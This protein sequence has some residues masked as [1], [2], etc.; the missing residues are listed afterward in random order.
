MKIERMASIPLIL[1]DPYISIWSSTDKLYESDPVHWS[2]ARQK[3]TGHLILNGKPYRFMGKQDLCQNMEQTGVEVTATASTYYFE[4]EDVTLEVCFRSSFLLEDPVLVSRPC[5]YIDFRIGGAYEGKQPQ[6]AVQ[7][8][9]DIV[10]PGDE[11]VI[12]GAYERPDYHY[13]YMGKARQTPLCYSGDNRTIDWGYCYLASGQA[14]ADIRHDWQDRTLCA[15]FDLEQTPEANLIFAFDD[16]SSIQYFGDVKRGYWTT[17]YAHILDAIGAAIS[18]HDELK[19]RCAQFDAQL[20]AQARK[21]GG[22]DYALLCVAAYRHTIA[23][24][25]LIAD[26]DGNLIFLS[27]ETDSNG[28]IGTVDLSY[29]SSPMFLLYNTEYVKG[30]MRPIFHFAN[31]D[32]WEND[33]APHDV[34]RYPYAVGQVYALNW[35]KPGKELNYIEGTTCT[36]LYMFPAGSGCYVMKEQMPVEESGN[37][38]IMAAAVTLLD[39]NT[40]FIADKMDVMEKWVYYL[41]KHGTDPGEQLCT[42]DFAGHLAHNANLSAKAV[43]GI[44]AFAQMKKMLGDQAAYERFH[45]IAAQMAMMWEKKA[46]DGDH[47]RLTFDRENTWSLKYNL[48]WDLFFDSHLFSE[49][50]FEQEA[51]YYVTRN[52]RYGAPL[53][54]RADYTKSDWVLWCAAFA[55]DPEIRAQIIHPVAEYLRQTKTRVPFSDWYDTKTGN[56]VHFIGRS[57]QGGMFAP[58]LIE[59]GKSGQQE[60]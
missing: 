44:E 41:V 32:V 17:K 39:G 37:M 25:K 38:L 36:F 48:M 7:V 58:M 20:E 8:S 12:G 11:M 40:Q 52:N 47:T 35:D 43:L 29:P 18:E 50:L 24:H 49:A 13:A 53:D 3:I 30:M 26:N 4:A 15:Q 14:S 9:S 45:E 51:A 2:R 22:E 10:T 19:S 21:V 59:S 34:G 56:F 1:Q 57:V 33:F 5:T 60:E 28:C 46:A 31:C 16:I 54:C 27:K 55:K 23:A 6:V 42:D